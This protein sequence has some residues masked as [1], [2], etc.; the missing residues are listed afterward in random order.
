MADML[1]SIIVVRRT[2]AKCKTHRGSPAGMRALRANRFPANVRRVP[3]NAN[4]MKVNHARIPEVHE[5]CL[6]GWTQRHKDKLLAGRPC[7]R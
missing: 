3:V 6:V 1:L 2:G 7:L 4:L 5:R